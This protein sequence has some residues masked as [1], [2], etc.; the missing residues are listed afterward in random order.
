[1][2][3][4]CSSSMPP[5]R[6]RLRRS[7]S[8]ITTLVADTS[9]MACQLMASAFG[10]N[11][12]PIEVAALAVDSLEVQRAVKKFQPDVAVIS[13]GLKDGPKTGLK[14]ARELWVSGSKT[15]AI[16]LI[17]ASM[18]GAVTEVFR[19]GAHGII[20]RDEPFETLCKCINVVH[21]GQVWISSSQLLGLIDS[22]VKSAPPSIVTVDGST[23]LT[24]REEGVVGLVAQGLTNRAISHQLNLS[25]HTVRNY[26]FRIFNKLGTANR[27]E[28][29]LYVNNQKVP[30]QISEDRGK[31]LGSHNLSPDL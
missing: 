2:G 28:L 1:M 10:Q 24:K 31:N 12:Y 22:L 6:A 16:I 14:A 18:S 3:R 8:P 25:E 21:Q 20:G 13:A 26:L 17:D 15:K 29:A 7:V 30:H 9:R 23:L 5:P 4:K 19:A 11:A 27:L